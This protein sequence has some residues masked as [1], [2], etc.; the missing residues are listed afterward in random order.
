MHALGMKQKLNDFGFSLK[1][2]QKSLYVTI[3][4]TKMRRQFKTVDSSKE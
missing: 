1:D 3:Q 4:Y 2:F